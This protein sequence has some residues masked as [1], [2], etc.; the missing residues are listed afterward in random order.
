MSGI[1][2]GSKKPAV[3]HSLIAERKAAEKR[4]ADEKAEIEARKIEEDLARRRGLRGASSLIS[5]GSGG[6]GFGATDT[7]G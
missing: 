4:L 1:L 6:A 5:G 3:D 2:G 7:L